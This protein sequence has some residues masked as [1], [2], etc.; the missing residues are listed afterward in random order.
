MESVNVKLCVSSREYPSIL[1]AFP[2]APRITLQDLTRPDMEAVVQDRFQANENFRDLT[3]WDR[4][5]LAE[6]V[7]SGVATYHSLELLIKT[8]PRELDE[9]FAKILDSMPKHYAR[10]AWFVLAMVLRWELEG[11]G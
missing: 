9:F 7:A 10:Q 6:E 4:H 11:F 8:A 5:D 1:N 3:S 2:A